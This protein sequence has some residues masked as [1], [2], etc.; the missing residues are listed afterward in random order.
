MI[1]LA[2]AADA[3]D[4]S[5]YI[6][7]GFVLAGVALVLLFLELLVPS[8]GLMGLLCGVAVIGSIVA[9]F[10]HDTAFGISSVIAYAILTPVTLVFVFKLW[11]H[12]PLGKRMV[13]G[14]DVGGEHGDAESAMAA[15]EQAR[16][17]RLEA[18][19]ELVGVEGVAA[20]ALRPVGVVK[21]NGQRIDAL[22]ES[23][24]IEAGTPVVVAD[25]YDNQV[26]VRAKQR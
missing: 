21:I 22:A 26:K 25:V 9:F 11:L 2:Q 6:I 15:S 1:A 16:R 17:K 24:V 7:W 13:L 8:G 20:T 5:T 14:A 3:A 23:G 12:S 19:R 4:G 18:L 10:K